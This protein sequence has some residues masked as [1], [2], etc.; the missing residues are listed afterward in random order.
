MKKNVLLTGILSLGFAVVSLNV[1][2]QNLDEM[3]LQREV[4]Q[5]NTDLMDKKMDLEKETQVN[6]KIK[7]NVDSL[8]LKSDKKTD[9][10]SSSD[11]N[12]TA[13]DARNTAKLL[14]KTESANKDLDRSNNK[15]INI[16]ADIKKLET[17][18]ER[19]KYAV[20]VKQ[21]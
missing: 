20:E 5:L 19:L 3:K 9:N 15:I 7:G 4:L 6:S 11:P 21:K 10:F 16:E 2:A 17:K 13:K 12:S 8:N 18:I 14:K 1:K